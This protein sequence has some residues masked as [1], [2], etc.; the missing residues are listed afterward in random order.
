MECSGGLESFGR[1]RRSLTED[2]S[3]RIRSVEEEEDEEDEEG[4]NDRE[5]SRYYKINSAL[6]SSTPTAGT[7]ITKNH[8]QTVI[9]D[10]INTKA[11][12]GKESQM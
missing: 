10:E 6:I 4:D 11:E 7:P 12:D 8:S 5:T 1:R 9:W 3:R 2:I